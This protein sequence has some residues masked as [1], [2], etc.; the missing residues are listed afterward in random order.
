MSKNS[1]NSRLTLFYENSYA[2]KGFNA[3]RR[4][5]NEELC[6]FMGRNFF[7]LP[8]PKRTSTKILEVGCGSGANLWMIAREGFDAYGI[9]LSE[10]G[11][12]LCEEMLRSYDCA[13]QLTVG[14]MTKTGYPDQYFDCV[15]DV[16]SSNCLTN[17]GGAQFLKEVA[18]L[19]KPGGKFFSYFPSKASDT[20]TKPN[21]P[22]FDFNQKLDKDT[23][24]GLHRSGGPY[25]GNT[26]AFRFLHPEEYREMLTAAGLRV[27]YLERVGRSYRGCNEYFEFLV[28]EGTKT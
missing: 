15:V 21:H 9:D 27:N 18:R 17:A 24:N 3:Q 6:R 5:P 10:S 26:Y 12:A 8:S 28:V 11:V 25:Y 16:F 23:L 14:D 19:L 1:D 20:W 22:D 7:S 13:A 2:T 4:Y